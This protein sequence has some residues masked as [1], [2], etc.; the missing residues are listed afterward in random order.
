MNDKNREKDHSQV[1]QTEGQH[2]SFDRKCQDA[3]LINPAIYR[4]NTA[5]KYMDGTNGKVRQWTYG[6]RDRDKQN[7][8]VLMVGETGAGKTTMIST[9]ISYLLGVKFEEE[10]FYQITVE[11]E[12]HKDQSKSQ[13]SEITVYEEFFEENPSSLTLIDIPGYGH[14]EG[15]KEDRETAD[16][17]SRLFSDKDGIHYIDAVCFVIKASQKRLSGKEFY[18]FHSVLSLFGRD[19]ED[20]MVFLLTHSDG[21]RPTDALNAI[22]TAE[23]PCRR[24]ERGR[25]VHFLFNNRQKEERDEEYKHLDGFAWEMGN[26]SMN[27]FFRLLEEKNRKS[28]QMTLDVLKER[29]RLEACVPNLKERI[30]EE[31]LKT[32]ELTEIQE[33]LRQNREKIEKC[34]NFKFTV[35]RH[36]KDKVLIKNVLVWD[37]NATCCDVCQENCHEWFC[38]FVENLS[39]CEVMRNNYCTMCPGKCHYSKHVKENKKYEIKTKTITM[40][41]DELKQEY[42]C[43]GDQPVTSFNKTTYEQMKNEHERSMRESGNTTT[44]EEKLKDNLEQ[45]K[46][47]KSKMLHE[48]Y[49]IITGLSKIALKADSAFTLQHLEFLIL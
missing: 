26:K 22:N 9:M 21:R 28:V 31:E 24:D 38:W 27:E 3:T 17:L 30:S 42:E 45:I 36:F 23:I 48:A 46:K 37:R 32:K 1:N 13:T 41:F 16:Y 33:A 6:K 39:L 47:E 44:I 20:N 35:N 34:E 7:K 2:A 5:R 25:P 11:E 29:R 15:Y 10:L 40:T 8:V 18:I 4:L 12:Q 49:M 19:I 14:T 43:T